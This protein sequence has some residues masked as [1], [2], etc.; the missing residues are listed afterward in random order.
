M[1]NKT[2]RFPIYPMIISICMAIVGIIYLYLI[3]LNV[4]A[5]IESKQEIVNTLNSESM[6]FTNSTALKIFDEEYKPSK[7]QDDKK[8]LYS[9]TAPEGFIFKSYSK[10][11]TEDK[12]IELYAELKLNKHGEEMDFL[13]E[14]VIYPEEDSSALATHQEDIVTTDVMFH[15]PALPNDFTVPINRTTGIINLY[16]GN[17]NKTIESMAVS[18]SHEYGHHYT[19]YHM[20][21]RDTEVESE[22]VKVRGLPKDKV[23][24]M[25]NDYRLYE[26]EYVWFVAEIAAN[27]YVLLMGSPTTRE[28]MDFV[29]VREQLYGAEPTQT[30][31][32][33]MNS[34]PQRNLMIPLATDVDGLA[35]YFYSFID[36]NPPKN[37]VKEQKIEIKIEQQ[38]EGYN[39]T[40]GYQTFVYYHITFNTPY[41][42][43]G[44]V[45]TLVCYDEEDYHIIPIKTINSDENGSAYIGTVVSLSGGYVT[46]MWDSLDSGTKTFRVISLFPDGTLIMSDPLKYTF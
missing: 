2:K 17:V 22:Y 35:E 23:Y 9:F 20:F 25:D 5:R 46:W 30:V 36:E 3:Q 4:T 6:D 26:S 42:E 15:F 37:T 10:T 38:S 19:F 33:Y 21:D 16:G 41:S 1:T 32:H 45:Y 8:A 14:I 39:L 11:W 13:S 44:V 7:S 27:D 40:T 24:S 31:L 34:T 18:L 29:D 28:I 12:L 43:K